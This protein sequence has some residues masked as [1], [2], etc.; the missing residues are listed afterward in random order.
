MA[1]WG[2]EG[3]GE[4]AVRAPKVRRGGAKAAAGGGHVTH[5]RRAKCHFLDVG[6]EAKRSREILRPRP[7]PSDPFEAPCHACHRGWPRGANRCGVGRSGAGPVCA[8][9]CLPYFEGIAFSPQERPFQRRTAACG[10][11]RRSYRWR[12]TVWIYRSI[13]RH[14]GAILH[15]LRRLC[16]SASR[17][18]F[19][20]APARHGGETG[21]AMV[22]RACQP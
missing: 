9:R 6:R 15:L 5:G 21:A 11:F 3:R 19:R 20:C 1:A 16:A 13:L 10:R 18:V 17:P 4:A 12:W 2:A 22:P 14:Q 7:R 8:A